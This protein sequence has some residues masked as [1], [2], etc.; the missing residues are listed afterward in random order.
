MDIPALPMNYD[1]QRGGPVTFGSDERLH[2]TFSVKSI[3]NHHKSKLE[4]R[5]VFEGVVF[6]RIQ[7][8]GE[9]DCIEKPADQS[10]ASRFPRQWTAFQQGREDVPVGTILSVLFPNN[11]EIIDMMKFQKI[12][13]VEQLATCNE[14]QIQNLGLGGR[15][16]V[17]KA[18]EYLAASQKG[19]G[20]HELEAKLNDLAL[21]VQEKDTRIAALE[22]ALEA[23]GEDVSQI[24]TPA[25]KRRGRPPKAA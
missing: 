4:G 7:Q 15:N 22:K 24:E 2:V 20:F 19:K 8:P 13:T 5:P 17:D 18:K 1:A 10:H 25:P 3:Q 16:F 12:Q 21:K 14:T 9:R 6:V 11:P 23:A